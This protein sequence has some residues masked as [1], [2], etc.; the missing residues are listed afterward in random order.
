MIRPAHEGLEVYLCIE[1]VDFRRQINGLATLV[2]DQLEMNPFSTQLF[3][4]TNRRR[5][6]ATFNIPFGARRGSL[7][8]ASAAR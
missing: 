1:P 8:V 5:H 4:F 7:P 3:C 2:Q 6:Q